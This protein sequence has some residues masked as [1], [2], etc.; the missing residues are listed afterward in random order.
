[1]HEDKNDTMA[2]QDMDTFIKKV[3]RHEII[4][5]FLIESGLNN[6]SMKVEYWAQNEEMV[7]WIAYQFPKI[8]MVFKEIGCL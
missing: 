4:H 7:D 5:A 6:N 8:S 2:L 1:M 3:I